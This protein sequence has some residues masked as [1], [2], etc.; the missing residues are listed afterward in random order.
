MR[1]FAVSANGLRT[2][3]FEPQALNGAGPPRVLVGAISCG[4]FLCVSSVCGGFLVA[5]P[6]GFLFPSGSVSLDSSIG[7]TR[8]RIVTLTQF[9]RGESTGEDLKVSFSLIASFTHT[10]CP[11]PMR[12]KA[13]G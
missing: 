5:P 7:C 13:C 4:C 6:C 8:I 9:P 2:W 11:F 12:D 1:H 10:R 3:A